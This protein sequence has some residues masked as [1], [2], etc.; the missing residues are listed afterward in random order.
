MPGNTIRRLL[1]FSY[2]LFLHPVFK[3][4]IIGVL[5][6]SPPKTDFSR[7]WQ[8]LFGSPEWPWFIRIDSFVVSREQIKRARCGRFL[9]NFFFE[10]PPLISQGHRSQQY[11]RLESLKLNRFSDPANNQRWINLPNTNYTAWA[12]DA[13]GWINN[14]PGERSDCVSAHLKEP[15][16]DQRPNPLKGEA[17]PPPKKW[18]FPI[19]GRL[20]R[21][22]LIQCA[23]C[24]ARLSPFKSLILARNSSRNIKDEEDSAALRSYRRLL[25]EGLISRYNWRNDSKHDCSIWIPWFGKTQESQW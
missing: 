5:I 3:F 18:N 19:R 25:S 12:A 14:S 9:N 20:C 15:F 10:W 4:L 1:E 11:N 7:A 2:R 22:F 17:T 21:I 8:Q 24:I 6:L 23:S 13:L 16:R